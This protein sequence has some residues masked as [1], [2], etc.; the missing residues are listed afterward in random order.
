MES[1]PEPMLLP[2]KPSWTRVGGIDLGEARATRATAAQALARTS[3]ISEREARAAFEQ[4]RQASEREMAATEAELQRVQRELSS[5]VSPVQRSTSSVLRAEVDPRTLAAV[6]GARDSGQVVSGAR[7]RE[8]VLTL[9]GS[10]SGWMWKMAG[11]ARL[12]NPW[13]K[14]WFILESNK[15]TY[16]DNELRGTLKGTVDL[17]V[18][19]AVQATTPDYVDDV[20]RRYEFEVELPKRTYRF[21]CENAENFE[22]WLR[23]LRKGR[24]D[25]RLLTALAPK[26]GIRSDVWL[27]DA[28]DA[29][30]RVP[31]RALAKMVATQSSM[32]DELGVWLEGMSEWIPLRN[33]VDQQ[34]VPTTAALSG[35]G[36]SGGSG[37]GSSGTYSGLILTYTRQLAPGLGE[38]TLT[39]VCPEQV[40]S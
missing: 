2:P 31:V 23:A 10:Q 4:Q 30:R 34:V 13:Q 32:L 19:T 21:R 6:T 25:P 8:R 5:L 9:R 7:H 26:C 24:E 12:G 35:G 40:V 29:S 36:S 20:E 33:I 15:L 38:L 27:A 16:Y 28:R 37:S 3:S 14:R 11:G 1:E 22:H 18:C 17:S 39:C